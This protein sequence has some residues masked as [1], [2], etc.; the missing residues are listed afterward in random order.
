MSKTEVKDDTSPE[1]AEPES[2]KKKRPDGIKNPGAKF[3]QR[4]M[5]KNG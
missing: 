2:S 1:V 4:G 5:E 3:K